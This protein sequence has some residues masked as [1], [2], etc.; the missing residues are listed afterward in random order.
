MD[1]FH[2]PDHRDK[3]VPLKVADITITIKHPETC[4]NAPNDS[5]VTVSLF[6]CRFPVVSHVLLDQPL[7]G[8]AFTLHTSCI[9]QP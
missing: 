8:A 3:A 1:V 6:S 2:I 5:L 7:G 4:I 9:V